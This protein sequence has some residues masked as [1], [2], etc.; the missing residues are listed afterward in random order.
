MPAHPRLGNLLIDHRAYDGS[1]FEADTSTCSHC[2]RVVVLRADR[3]RARA[4]CAKCD[5]YICDGCVGRPCTPFARI[6]ENFNG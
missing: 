4:Y 1:V 3:T 5:H 2:Q 6:L